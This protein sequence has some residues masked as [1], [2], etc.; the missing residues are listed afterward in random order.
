M[1]YTK[2]Y[3]IGRSAN[4]TLT[5]TP[6]SRGMVLN[7]QQVEEIVHTKLTG[8]TTATVTLVSITRPSAVFVE[9]LIDAAAAAVDTDTRVAVTWAPSA[10]AR[11]FTVSSLGTYT[12]GR[13]IVL[14]RSDV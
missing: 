11:T 13:F 12:R 2:L 5:S 3:A 7:G 9:P 4:A 6:Q 14:G 10:T 1:A 8:D